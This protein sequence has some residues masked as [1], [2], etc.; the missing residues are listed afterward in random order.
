MKAR[1]SFTGI[2]VFLY[3][4]LSPVDKKVDSRET[5]GHVKVRLEW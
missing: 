5:V 4:Q 3:A 2:S 1:D